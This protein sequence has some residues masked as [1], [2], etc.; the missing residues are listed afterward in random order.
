MSKN[1]NA[2]LRRLNRENVTVFD[3]VRE[4]PHKDIKVSWTGE[5]PH[6]CAGTWEILLSG[7]DVSY[8]IPKNIR[9][10][11]MNTE[12][13]YHQW[14]FENWLD[15]WE[16]V[17]QGLPFNEW[18][19]KNYQWVKKLPLDSSQYNELYDA[20]RK[21]DWIHGSCGGCI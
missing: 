16:T 5:Y 6:L 21:E 10:S 4:I 19:S 13:N 15:V 8:I 2:L 12:K 1:I 9:F 7:E 18:L 11:P 14:H 3:N 20:I 17:H